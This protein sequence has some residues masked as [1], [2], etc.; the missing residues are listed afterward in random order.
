MIK[1]GQVPTIIRDKCTVTQIAE[2]NP[3]EDL[4][5]K[6]D[7]KPAVDHYVLVDCQD[8]YLWGVDLTAAKLTDANLGGAGLGGAKLTGAKLIGADLTEADLT[9]AKLI[10]ADLKGAKLGGAKLIG[11]DFDGA[12]LDGVKYTSNFSAKQV[13]DAESADLGFYFDALVDWLTSE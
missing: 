13:W 12:R 7:S 4:E 5:A 11:A 8:A 9:E 6:G 3:S 1:M 10:G 2:K